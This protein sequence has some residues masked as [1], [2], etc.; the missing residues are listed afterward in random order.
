MEQ[1]AC[2]PIH[3]SYFLCCTRKSKINAAFTL[4]AKVRY[5]LGTNVKHT[6]ARIRVRFRCPGTRHKRGHRAPVC[7]RLCNH[8]K[9]HVFFLKLR[10]TRGKWSNYVHSYISGTHGVNSTPLWAGT[11]AMIP[12]QCGQ[13]L[14]NETERSHIT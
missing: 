9:A 10:L 5:S 13:P 2:V 12:G 3:V 1:I 14:R 11:K 7:T 8:C 6:H 4:G